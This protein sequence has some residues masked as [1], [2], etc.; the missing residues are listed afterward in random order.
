MQGPFLGTKSVCWTAV[1]ADGRIVV[2]RWSIAGLDRVEAYGVDAVPGFIA[3]IATRGAF[4]N[5]PDIVLSGI[6]LGLNTG[7]AVLHSGTVGAAMTA[8]VHGCRALAVSLAVGETLHWDTAA[9]VARHAIGWLLDIDHPVVLNV[10]VPNV[11]VDELRGVRQGELAAFGA[12]QTTIAEVGEGFVRVGVADVRDELQP[13]SDAAL[14]A[15]GYASVTPLSP[16]CESTDLILP[17]NGVSLSSYAEPRTSS[18][19]TR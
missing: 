11:A 15:E 3:L 9:D 2:E 13:G 6:N 10:N 12:V 5:P 7:H 16:L 4:G 19:G 17:V 18:P 1:Q 14:V 8:R